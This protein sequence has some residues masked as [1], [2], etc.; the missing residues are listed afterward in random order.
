MK[1]FITLI[2]SLSF[3]G[4]YAQDLILKDPLPLPTSQ[5]IHTFNF[6]RDSM[7][8]VAGDGFYGAEESIGKCGVID[9]DYEDSRIRNATNQYHTNWIPYDGHKRT[10]CGSLIQKASYDYVKN[11]NDG[12]FTCFLRPDKSFEYLIKNS[13][14]MD[15]NA[16]YPGS[17]HI[18]VGVNNAPGENLITD[19][20]FLTKN[21]NTCAYGA[22]VEDNG[23]LILIVF[24]MTNLNL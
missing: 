7:L 24:V 6:I 18:E 21:K 15:G 23:T 3:F 5:E 20:R 13:K 16:D 17:I 1:L 11:N 19:Y 2:I 12:D 22:W 14:N 4:L 9:D 10:V 8:H